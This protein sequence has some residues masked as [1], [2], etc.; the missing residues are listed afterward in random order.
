MFD[1]CSFVPRM[2][3]ILAACGVVAVAALWSRIAYVI[4]EA[5]TIG[6]YALMAAGIIAATGAGLVAVYRV[7]QRIQRR[8]QA[9]GACLTCTRPCQ[10]GRPADGPVPVTLQ[11]RRSMDLVA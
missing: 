8:Q 6:T 7:G 11:A 5:W 9:R 3:I 2:V 10:V 1:T 4:N